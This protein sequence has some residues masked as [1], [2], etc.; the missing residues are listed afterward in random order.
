MAIIFFFSEE[1]FS[2]FL[3][4]VHFIHVLR[5]ISEKLFRLV[6]QPGQGIANR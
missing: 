4:F 6:D 5:R 3:V 2:Y 1:L